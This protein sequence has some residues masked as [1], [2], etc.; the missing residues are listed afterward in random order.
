MSDTYPMFIE[1]KIT[2]V[3]SWFSGY[4][5][6]DTKIGLKKNCSFLELDFVNSDLTCC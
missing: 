6:L 4:I 1:S 2:W 5:W 3:P